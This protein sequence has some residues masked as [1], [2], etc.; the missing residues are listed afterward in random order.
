[1]DPLGRISREFLKQQ[2]AKDLKTAL[3]LG[4]DLK[5]QGMRSEQVEE[6]LYAND[7]FDPDVIDEAIGTLFGRSK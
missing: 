3:M 1:M 6:M 4:K 7:G 2:R 5:K